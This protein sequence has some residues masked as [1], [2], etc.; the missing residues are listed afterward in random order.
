MVHHTPAWI[1]MS[2]MEQELNLN[3]RLAV[4]APEYER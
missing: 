1:W 2:M 4:L 3:P